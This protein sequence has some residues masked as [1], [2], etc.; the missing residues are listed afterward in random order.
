V[1]VLEAE[2]RADSPISHGVQLR[3]IGRGPAIRTRVFKWVDGALWWNRGTGFSVAAGETFPASERGLRP[4]LD[5]SGM[6]TAAG[7]SGI[8]GGETTNQDL[9]VIC[10]DQLGNTLL[11]NMRTGD[12]PGLSR[13]SDQERPAWATASF[14]KYSSPEPP[15]DPAPMIA[16]E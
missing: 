3:N 6:Q 14:D 7:V 16:W 1:F 4:F 12:P 8:P 11:F 9:F 10:L 5:L 13:P 15:I 2:Q